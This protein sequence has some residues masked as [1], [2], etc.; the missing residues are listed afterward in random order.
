MTFVLG[1]LLVVLIGGCGG[2]DNKAADQP[3]L[4]VSAAASL[5]DAFTQIGQDFDAAD[6]RFQFAG[7]DALA[8]QIRQGARPDVFAAANT[9]LPDEL[10][11]EGLVERPV[12]F[13]TNRLVVIVPKDSEI[14]SLDDLGEDGVTIAA[15]AKSVPV[16]SYTRKVLDKL[17]ATEGRAIIA[18]IRS[19]EPDVKGVVGKVA[20]GAV[21]AGFVYVTDA[22]AAGD[23][24]RA[25][26]L[27]AE[28][29]PEV[30]YGVAVVKGGKQPAAAREF[31][32]ALT[33]TQ[34][35]DVLKSE[36]FGSPPS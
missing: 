4:T 33:G 13:T 11:A 26:E 16:G 24:V 17:P 1:M 9:K 14:N 32:K 18:N 25:I 36:G 28:L 27:P 30:V 7:S 22:T 19:A 3:Q 12:K 20:N 6:A 8:A 31:V 5:S 15:G 23:D 21:D 29:Q 34:A 10:F 2:D 35:Q